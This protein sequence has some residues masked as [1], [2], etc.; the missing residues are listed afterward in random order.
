VKQFWLLVIPFLALA[1]A[2]TLSA[3]TFI[4]HPPSPPRYAVLDTRRLT[5]VK[6]E[7]TLIAMQGCRAAYVAP[8]RGSALW[9]AGMTM[10]LERLPE[11]AQAPEYVLVEE[12][13]GSAIHYLLD[14]ARKGFRYVRNSAFVHRGHDF[15][16]DFWATAVFGEKHVRHERYD[17]FTNYILLELSKDN[18]ACRYRVQQTDPGHE[19]RSPRRHFAEGFQVAGEI[20][21]MLVLENCMDPAIQAEEG[22]TEFEEATV[23]E[24]YRLLSSTDS[25][26]RQEELAEAVTSG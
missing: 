18:A 8:R 20:E 12:K 22:A 4:P 9:P 5:T 21:R 25:K 7:L 15:W 3:Q 13:N 14:D 26:K 24:R 16:G 2:P 19:N 10:I 1:L 17:T 23:K 11:G 6:Q